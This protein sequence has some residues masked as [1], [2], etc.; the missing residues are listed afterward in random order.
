MMDLAIQIPYAENGLIQIERQLP[1]LVR[2]HARHNRYFH[3][4]E[5]AL[6]VQQTIP[7]LRHNDCTIGR[8]NHARKRRIGDFSRKISQNKQAFI[9]TELLDPR[10]DSGAKPRL[11]SLMP[12]LCRLLAEDHIVSV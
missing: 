7:I 11:L 6:P 8:L 10:S 1:I 9:G 12:L 2:N 4:V 5:E 3:L